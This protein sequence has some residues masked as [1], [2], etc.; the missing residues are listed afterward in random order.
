MFG[1]P[2]CIP[3]SNRDDEEFELIKR[4]KHLRKCKERLWARWSKDYVKALRERHNLKFKSK[5]ILLKVNDVVLIRG[6]EPNRGKWKIGIVES[7]I[8]GNDGVMRAATLRCGKYTLQR[9]VQQLY[10]LELSCDTKKEVDSTVLN[11]DAREFRPKRDAAEVARLQISDQ[12]N[13]E[14][15]QSD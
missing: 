8:V 5:V 1:K 7:L 2:N 9:A 13:F 10:P 14:F 15:E 12:M 3:E 4:A 6:D 11:A